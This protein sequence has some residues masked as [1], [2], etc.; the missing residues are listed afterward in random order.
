MT[1]SKL[2]GYNV[3]YEALLVL[4][5]FLICLCDFRLDLRLDL[6]LFL[7]ELRFD[8]TNILWL[9]FDL[10]FDLTKFVDWWLDLRFDLMKV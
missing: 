4:T 2:L 9:R 6:R 10:R 7:G 8:L 3:K 5:A 1:H